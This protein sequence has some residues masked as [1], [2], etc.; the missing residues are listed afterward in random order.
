MEY[1]S[2]NKAIILWFV[3]Q[4]G[5]NIFFKCIKIMNHI[6]LDPEKIQKNFKYSDQMEISIASLDARLQVLYCLYTGDTAVLDQAIVMVKN[7]SNSRT[8]RDIDNIYSTCLNIQL[9]M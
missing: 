8:W 9:L 5:R 7:Q 4:Y 6:L 1:W 2:Q 3:T